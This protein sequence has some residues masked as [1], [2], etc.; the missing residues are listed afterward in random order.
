VGQLPLPA[1]SQKP[2][3]KGRVLQGDEAR[4]GGDILQTQKYYSV[5]IRN[6]DRDDRWEKK[7]E[8]RQIFLYQC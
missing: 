3:Q 5:S 8:E 6:L 4:F 1:S 7:E 2:P